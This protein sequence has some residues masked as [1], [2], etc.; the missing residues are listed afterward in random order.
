VCVGLC[1]RIEIIGCLTIFLFLI[2]NTS[3]QVV[4]YVKQWQKLQISAVE[5]QED[6]ARLMERI[7]EF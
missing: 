1:G 6:L 4:G 5:L 7:K 2:L 3:F